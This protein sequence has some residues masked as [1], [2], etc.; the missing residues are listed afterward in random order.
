MVILMGYLGAVGSLPSPAEIEAIPAAV[1][2][3]T[4]ELV[5]G[6]CADELIETQ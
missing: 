1:E 2:I 4:V 3:I 6:F 5:V